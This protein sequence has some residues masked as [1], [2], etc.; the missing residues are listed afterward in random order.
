MKS[1]SIAAGAG[2]A[3]IGVTLSGCLGFSVN[4]CNCEKVKS[5]QCA[6][7]GGGCCGTS[8]AAPVVTAQPPVENLQPP[9][10]NPPPAPQ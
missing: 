5:C 4:R 8:H 2:L 7:V 1:K 9:V 3:L 6:G 10:E